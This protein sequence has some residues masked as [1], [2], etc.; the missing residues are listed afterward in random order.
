MSYEMNLLYDTT[1]LSRVAE[2]VKPLGTYLRDTFF[3]N[4]E[5]FGT[6]TVTFDIEDDEKRDLAGFSNIHSGGDYVDI[7]GF[8]TISYKP[9]LIHEKIFLS[10]NNDV[11]RVAGERFG[12]EL[13]PEQRHQRK[14]AQAVQRLEH[15][16]QRREEKMA[17]DALFTGK[18]VIQGTGVNDVVDFWKDLGSNKPFTDVAVKWDQEGADPLADL[19]AVVDKTSELYGSTPRRVILGQKAAKVLI[20]YLL[21]T[22][23]LDN[24]RIDIGTINPRELPSEVRFLGTL[25]LPFVDLY[26]YT[27]NYSE[28]GK[29][30]PMVP[31]N[32]VLVACDNV[33]TVRAYGAL[34]YVD[35]RSP[36][37][38]QWVA[39]SRVA[40][41]YVKPEA[42]VGRIIELRSRPLFIINKPYGFHVMKVCDE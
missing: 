15:R 28:N 11:Y 12:G 25:R 1:V 8:K 10:A 32:M 23:I 36:Q 4:V 14:I 7:G 5:T 24:R 17:S 40:S 42:N 29:T 34:S 38:I 33:P 9:A 2:S 37:Q 27:A 22:G 3:K 31:A 19:R 39:S 6:E 21:R 26:E 30:I 13:T 16:V 41:T 35:P 20:D 18:I